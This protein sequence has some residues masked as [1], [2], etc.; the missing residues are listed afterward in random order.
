MKERK[1]ITHSNP[2]SPISEAYRT[3]RTNIQFA[4]LDNPIKV[5]M[6][7][8]SGP[9]EG[10]TTTTANLA[11]TMAQLGA[12]VLVM[13][14]DLRKPAVHKAFQLSNSEGVTNILVKDLNYKEFLLK[15]EVEGLEVLPSGAIPPNPSELLASQK[16]KNFIHSLREDYDYILIDTPPA[17]IVTDAALLSTA[18]DGVILVCAAGEVA[19][20]GA[21]RAKELLDNVNANIIG[22]VLNKIPIGKKGSSYYSY[23][24][25]SSYYGEEEPVKNKKNKRMKQHG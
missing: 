20:Q 9:G 11:V 25:Y 1:I 13:D 3:L 5:L 2:K 22:V 10:K 14:A 19:I 4:S 21:Q 17:A 8:S 23:Y 15:T 24:Y 12:K 7:T 18:V 6:V 16:M